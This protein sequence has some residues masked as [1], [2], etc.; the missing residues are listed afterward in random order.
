ML[1]LETFQWV[2]TLQTQPTTSSIHPSSA[3][4]T[5]SGCESP[6]CESP[7]CES[8]GCESPGHLLGWAYPPPILIPRVLQW[9][10]KFHCHSRMAESSVLFRSTTFYRFHPA[11]AT[12]LGPSSSSIQHHPNPRFFQLHAHILS[13]NNRGRRRFSRHLMY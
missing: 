13:P 1:H 11:T 8:P 3:R 10:H 9:F 12:R 4:T 2:C 6:G 7:G 5:S